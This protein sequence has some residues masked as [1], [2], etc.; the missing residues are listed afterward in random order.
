M[1]TQL[2]ALA[3]AGAFA[4]ALVV[5][6]PAG[7]A[8]YPVEGGN[9]FDDSEQGW[10]GTFAPCT[11]QAG[12]VAPLCTQENV[13]VPAGGRDG[14]GGIAAR[15]TALV[16]AS[17]LFRGSST[18]RSPSFTAQANNGAGTLTYDR[19]LEAVNTVTVSPSATVDVY[20]VNETNG[21]ERLLGSEELTVADSAFASRQLTVAPGTLVAGRTYHLELRSTTSTQTAS[22]VQGRV[23]V[24]YDNVLLRTTDPSGASG[25]AGVTFPGAPLSETA[26][27]RLMSSLS[28]FAERGS[29]PGGSLVPL[30]RC[31]IVGTRGNDRIK[32]SRG[33]DVICGLGGKDRI[34]G[35]RGRDIVDAGKGNDRLG[36]AAG[37]DMLLGLAGK[38]RLVGASGKDRAGS[39][40]GADRVSGGRGNDRLVGASGADRLAGGAGRDRLNGGKGSDRMLAGAGRDAINARDRKR[41]RVNGGRGRDRAKIDRGRRAD[42]VRA[43]ER[44]R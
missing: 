39:G 14:T 37:H 8:T 23:E 9:T 38:D 25:S 6:G 21:G 29:G 17:E 30:A 31:T 11:T 42:R 41:D 15:T 4:V 2:R 32:G 7:A 36:G 13:Y 43:V 16:T 20:L 22:G 24:N 19:N 28:L 26:I 27:Q 40:A 3:V 1:S 44:R 18:W 35:G 5:V 33:N 12:D 10:T 34:N